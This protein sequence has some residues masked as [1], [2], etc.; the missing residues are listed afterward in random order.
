MIGPYVRYRIFLVPFDELIIGP[1]SKQIFFYF[2]SIDLQKIKKL[3]VIIIRSRGYTA[4]FGIFR[5]NDMI[6]SNTKSRNIPFH[7]TYIP[8]FSIPWIHV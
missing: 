7:A 8:A 6:I 2:L 3:H 4:I 5:P 1:F